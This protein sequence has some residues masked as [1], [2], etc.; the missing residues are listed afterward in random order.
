MEYFVAV[1]EERHFT[2]AARRVRVA[3]SGLSASIRSLERELGAPLFV[4]STRRVDLT[5]AGRALLVEARHALSTVDAAKEAVAAVEGLLRG[6]LA[7]GTLQCLGGVDL[8]G[9]LATFHAAH[10]RVEIELRQG[11]SPEL[12]ERVR[13]GDLDVAFV[14]APPEGTTGITYTTLLRQPMI[15]AC[16][17]GH[18]LADRDQVALSE[19]AD[20]TF[21]DFP[22]GWVTRDVTDR[23]LATAAVPRRV[24]LEVNDVHTLLD[25]VGHGMGVALVPQDFVH[26][27]T[28]ARFVALAAPAPEWHTAMAVAA[29]RRP[30]AAARR[31]MT[32]PSLRTVPVAAG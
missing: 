26:K 23:A 11:G 1:A 5:D 24:S 30:N 13:S 3:Q 25:L 32:L 4:R 14:S 9:A 15:L 27:P 6:T 17:P 2:R 29:A 7:V 20:E 16:A 8:V 21:V 18:P 22:P 10:P 31:L 12:V 28:T 19:L